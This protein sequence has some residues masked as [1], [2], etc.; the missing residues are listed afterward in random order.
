MTMV[1]ARGYSCPTPVLMTQKA[2][3]A[4]APDKLEVA[5]DSRCAVENVTR[6]AE[7]EGY[8]VTVA[9]FE[10]SYKLTLKK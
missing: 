4:G 7:G 9:D 2:V 8:K 3:K 6:Y 1:D 10:G 5:V